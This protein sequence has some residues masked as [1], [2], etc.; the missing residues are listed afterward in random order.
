VFP[1]TLDTSAWFW[2]AS[3]VGLLVGAAVV[4]Y[5]FYIAIADR[6]ATRPPLASQG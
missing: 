6:P 4:V 2:D 5:A 1:L 3:L